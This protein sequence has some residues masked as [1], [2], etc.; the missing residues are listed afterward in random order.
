[1]SAELIAGWLPALVA[2]AIG[3]G[4]GFALAR[5]RSADR[6][7]GPASPDPRA[8]GAAAEA[9]AAG[10]EDGA[11]AAGP[12]V[13]VDSDD[14]ADVALKLQAI[15]EEL[16]GTRNLMDEGEEEIRAFAEELTHLDA[17]IKRA[18]AR[19]RALL[20]EIKRRALRD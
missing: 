2:L 3:L 4:A 19:L 16:R 9:P 8:S 5:A 10:P 20:R 17:A 18:N 11:L 13:A 15:E 12:A 6:D 1:M 14:R 7:G